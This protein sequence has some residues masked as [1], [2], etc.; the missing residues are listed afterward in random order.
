MW[1]H[2]LCQQAC[3]IPQKVHVH[4]HKPQPQIPGAKHLGSTYH[5]RNITPPALPS[6]TSKYTPLPASYVQRQL[7]AFQT[8]IASSIFVPTISLGSLSASK[9]DLTLYCHEM[10]S[11]PKLRLRSDP[12]NLHDRC[13]IGLNREHC[14]KSFR[15]MRKQVT[16]LG[17]ILLAHEMEVF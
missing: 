15:Y 1:T 12:R 13:L 9:S 11:I 17:V 7:V 14:S 6:N 16:G 3:R 8:Y 10:Y 5:K 2:D 4:L